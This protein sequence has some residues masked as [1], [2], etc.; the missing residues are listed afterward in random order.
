MCDLI[1]C[2]STAM[3][4][5][6]AEEQVPSNEERRQ[7][8]KRTLEEQL[9]RRAE[10]S[11]RRR[12]GA[13]GVTVVVAAALVVGLLVFLNQDEKPSASPNK[14]S[15][16]PA[17]PTNGPCSY[18]PAGQAAKPVDMPPDPDPTPAQGTVNVA[19]RLNQGEVGL[20]LDRSKAPC[21]V[22]SF[23]HLVKAKYF[24]NTE[25]HRLSTAD[26]LKM[27]QCGDPSG[28]GKGGP[29]YSIKDEV[30]P[31]TTY[32]R[33]T[34]A[35]AK[36]AQPNSAG[37]QFFMVYGPTKLSSEYT[38]FG[39]IDEAGLK[40]LDKI[41]ETGSDKSSGPSEGKPNEPVRIERATTAT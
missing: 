17:T 11:K 30:K 8:A 37:S 14:N 20:T 5:S 40:V 18:Q 6:T 25:C 24:D 2:Q 16:K 34:L 9:E 28:S 38:V 4:R 10:K 29:G 3:Y 31:G 36:S 35:M 19:M 23:E 39:R 41:A 27:L 32:P 15:N 13:V 21:T 26:G 1:R 7:E 22:Q 33:G 12:R